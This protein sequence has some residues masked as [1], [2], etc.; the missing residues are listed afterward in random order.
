MADSDGYLVGC[1][2]IV[3]EA[4]SQRVGRSG[5]GYVFRLAPQAFWHRADEARSVV[6][7]FRRNV[8]LCDSS[9]GMWYPGDRDEV[10]GRRPSLDKR[11]ERAT[12]AVR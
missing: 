4:S 8:G 5:D 11:S 6:Q 7:Q 10:R 9:D 3:S 1:V 12:P 2:E